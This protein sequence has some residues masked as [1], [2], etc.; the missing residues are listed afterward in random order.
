MLSELTEFFTSYRNAWDRFSGA[1]IAA[2]YRI[3]TIIM[4][5]DGLSTYTSREE[6]VSKLQTNCD[7]FKNMGYLNAE[8][9]VGHFHPCG[10]DAFTIDLGWRVNVASGPVEY[11]TAYTCAAVDAQWCIVS[12]I[13]YKGSF[14]E[15][16]T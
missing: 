11:R 6:L 1:D 12:A 15:D 4:D 7:T 9:L 10:D 3:P 13:S 16:N 2:H 14:G 8:F 5:G